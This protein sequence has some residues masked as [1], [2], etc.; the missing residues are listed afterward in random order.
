MGRWDYGSK[1]VF[2]DAV[3]HDLL[4]D[5]WK[6]V[7]KE[8]LS[9]DQAKMIGF[10]LHAGFETGL[11]KNEIIEARPQWFNMRAKSLRVHETTTFQVKDR[12]PM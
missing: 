12:V 1:T 6:S 4:L 8:I 2:C 11:R 7:P 9:P 5:G 10:V 3:L